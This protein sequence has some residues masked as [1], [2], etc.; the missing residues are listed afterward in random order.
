[1]KYREFKKEC[2]ESGVPEEEL[3][4]ALAIQNASFRGLYSTDNAYWRDKWGTG[5]WADPPAH[6]ASCCAEGALMLESD[7]L[8]ILDKLSDNEGFDSLA[9][10]N[11][12]KHWTL[13]WS[14]ADS[15][16]ESAGWAFRE[17]LRVE[18]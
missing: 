12:N 13:E 3:L 14:L 11:D 2:K 1:M 16:S 7:S 17:A 4:L 18:Y 10:G 6:L 5:H 9:T 8:K 15:R